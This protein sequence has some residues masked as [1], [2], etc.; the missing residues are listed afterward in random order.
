MR[1]RDP[2]ELNEND[3]AIAIA[4][5]K[6]LDEIKKTERILEG[7]F[8]LVVAMDLVGNHVANTLIRPLGIGRAA[9]QKA[10]IETRTDPETGEL[11]DYTYGILPSPGELRDRR[12]LLLDGV[13]RTGHHLKI[14]E[15]YATHSSASEIT[16][17]A[18]Y[19]LG[20]LASRSEFLPT[21]W[22]EGPPSV[23]LEQDPE[24]DEATRVQLQEKR[25][26]SEVEW[27]PVRIT[28][29]WTELPAVDTP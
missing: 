14:L 8:D 23:R 12:V 21:W 4:T 6:L 27:A 25:L 5:K 26:R 20:P 9:V 28:F 11:L 7:R 22:A 19:Y 24:T 15:D 1:R 3:T 16:S 2:N 29:P 10:V 18:L 17:A 13:C